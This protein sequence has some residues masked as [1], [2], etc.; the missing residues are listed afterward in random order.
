MKYAPRHTHDTQDLERIARA[1]GVK[2][3]FDR[4]ALAAGRPHLHLKAYGLTLAS[5][6]S[7]HDAVIWLKGGKA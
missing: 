2:L 4:R 5:L 7:E 1:K 3:F 6:R